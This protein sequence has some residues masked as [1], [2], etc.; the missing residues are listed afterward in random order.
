MSEIFDFIKQIFAVPFGFTLST[1]YSMTG[2]Y[3]LAIVFLTI[4]FKLCFLPG[5]IRRQKNALKTKKYN[6]KINKIKELYVNEPD[7]IKQAT[8]AVTAKENLKK[9]GLGCLGFIVQF[10]IL[11]GLFNAINTPLSNVLNINDT[12]IHNMVTVMSDNGE[13]IEEGTNKTEIIILKNI[14]DYKETFLANGTLSE[15]TLD[16][17]VSFRDKFNFFGINLSYTPELTTFTALWG[18]PVLVLIIGMSSTLYSFLRIRKNNPST[19]KK[20]T[21]VQAL[22][23]ISPMLSFLFAFMFPAGVGLYWAISNLLSFIQRIILNVIFNPNKVEL[24]AEEEAELAAIEFK[25]ETN[26][27]ENVSDATNETNELPDTPTLT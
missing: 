23:F 21:A 7:K 15:S 10:I 6:L 1:F 14:D 17:I 16:E 2:N 4:L 8:Q 9:G 13:D 19:K 25:P 3:I 12:I 20:F 5:T 26:G 27:P 11:I 24:T 18:V 22:P